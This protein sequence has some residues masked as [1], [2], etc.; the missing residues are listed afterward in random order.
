MMH[1]GSTAKHRPGAP[2]RVLG[3][4]GSLRKG[5]FNTAALR[6]A[7]EMLPQGMTLELF[8]LSS[9]PPYNADVESA[10]DPESVKR[11]KL[12]IA[13]ADALLFATPE[14]NY[15]IPGVLKNAIDWASRP[16][17]ESPLKQKPAAVLGAGGRFGT[18]RA[19]NHLR[20]IAAGL[21]M[22]VLAKPEV[23]IANPAEKFN[24]DGRLVDEQTRRQIR[25]LLDALAG[26]VARLGDGHD[27]TISGASVAHSPSKAA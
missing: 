24:A 26:W 13:A 23:H 7:Q 5:S 12:R 27:S 21:N 17:G 10:G 25:A 9:I 18:V 1:N 4:S 22:L 11:L 6:A 15:S 14:Y 16:Q 2:V 20:Q 3:I 8:D 19:Q